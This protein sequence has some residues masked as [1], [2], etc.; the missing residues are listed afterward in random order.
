[1]GLIEDFLN[2]KP[3]TEEE[4]AQATER[5]RLMWDELTD[6]PFPGVTTTHGGLG[7]ASR[8]STTIGRIQFILLSGRIGFNGLEYGRGMEQYPQEVSYALEGHC[9]CSEPFAMRVALGVIWDDVIVRQLFTQAKMH[10]CTF[11]VTRI[12]M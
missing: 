3:L 1:M 2:P 12:D 6:E 4:I 9:P 8:L 7:L 11:P 5:M 10:V